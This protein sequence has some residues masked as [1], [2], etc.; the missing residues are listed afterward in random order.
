M[1]PS[2]F[3]TRR[4]GGGT[5]NRLDTSI[6][7]AMELDMALGSAGRKYHD[8]DNMSIGSPSVATT[9]TA[10]ISQVTPDDELAV[11]ESHGKKS[12]QRLGRTNTSRRTSP[13]SQR[14]V[15]CGAV[16]LSLDD[17]TR[18]FMRDVTDSFKQ[19]VSTV[20]RFGPEDREA[21]RA[22]LL[23]A[24]HSVSEKVKASLLPGCG[25]ADVTGDID[26]SPVADLES[27]V[28]TRMRRDRVKRPMGWRGRESSSEDGR[29][30]ASRDATR[31]KEARTKKCS[32]ATV[33]GGEKVA[34]S[35]TIVNT[36]Q[37][38]E[39]AEELSEMAVRGCEE[40]VHSLPVV[41]SFEMVHKLPVADNF[42]R[43]DRAKMFRLMEREC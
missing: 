21:V 35:N 32:D 9:V 24:R 2:S 18:W 36:R 5:L 14:L 1:R 38:K 11:K 37:K 23:E 43:F 27:N 3:A 4:P 17:E 7:A 31:W 10:N 30:C 8:D 28:N 22:T 33:D 39:N 16:G 40:V 19:I 13:E 41:D 12:R 6:T 20:R 42:D 26:A 29:L 15:M 25:R 34:H